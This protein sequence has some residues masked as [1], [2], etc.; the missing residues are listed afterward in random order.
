MVSTRYHHGINKVSSW[1]QQGIIMVSPSVDYTKVLNNI[2]FDIWGCWKYGD[3][4]QNVWTNISF[5][6][7]RVRHLANAGW[8]LQIYANLTLPPHWGVAI[9]HAKQKCCKVDEPILAGCLKW[10]PIFEP[11]MVMKET[12][13]CLLHNLESQLWAIGC[14]EIFN[15]IWVAY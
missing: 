13:N 9:Y 7:R 1:Y 4:S 8:Y 6:D 11:K 14:V 3:L 12:E 2:Y 15:S 10:R 5:L